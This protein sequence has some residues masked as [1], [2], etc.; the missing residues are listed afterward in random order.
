MIADSF[1]NLIQHIKNDP[2]KSKIVYIMMHEQRDD[3]GNISPKTIGKLLDNHVCI[4]GLFTIALRSIYS[5]G[6]YYFRTAKEGSE[7]VT[8]TPP[9]I[10]K[11]A[12]IDNDLK[13]VTD[14]IRSA[15]KLY[16]NPVRSEKKKED[17]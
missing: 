16:D 17:K 15:Y 14:K 3:F 2:N 11:D 10:F 7:D 5:E 9:G 4:E 1:W 6:K 12:E 13:L 8:K